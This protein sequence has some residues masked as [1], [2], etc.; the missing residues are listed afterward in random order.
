MQKKKKNTTK[1]ANQ[2]SNEISYKK[3][4]TKVKRKVEN[5]VRRNGNITF[6]IFLILRNM[7]FHPKNKLLKS[8]RMELLLLVKLI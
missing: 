3:G 1:W 7:V 6:C 8:I 5:D 2:K 4:R